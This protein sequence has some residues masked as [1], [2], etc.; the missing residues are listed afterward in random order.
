MAENSIKQLE[1]IASNRILRII[2]GAIV[3]ISMIL[4]IPWLYNTWDLETRSYNFSDFISGVT[5]TMELYV[6]ALI[7]GFILGLSLAI[8]RV[9]GGGVISRIATGYIE[10]IRGTPVVTQIIIIAFLPMML[11]AIIAPDGPP[12][13]P[14]SWDV[15]YMLST[16]CLGMNSAAYQA[17]FFRGSITSISSGQMLAATSLG[18]SKRQSI[19]HIILPQ[20]LRR[21]IPAWSN[22][23]SY[24]PKVTTAAYIVG[25]PEV[26]AFAKG[27][28]G[29]G[30][31]SMQVYMF[32]AVF[33]IVLITVVTW[34]L[35]YL[36]DRAKIPGL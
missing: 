10:V 8:A 22:E 28:A 29:Q 1:S 30:F 12:I 5:V 16:A 2:V 14:V 15:R 3:L 24:L 26:F 18:M 19:R 21:V 20:S 11:N 34:L 4:F 9:Y 13:F 32:V 35:D 17:E 36:Y 31:K 33:F 7:F 27:A 6:F 25:V 23:A